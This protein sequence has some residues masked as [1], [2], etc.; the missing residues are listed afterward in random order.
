MSQIVFSL[1][2]IRTNLIHVCNNNNSNDNLDDLINLGDGF[3]YHIFRCGS[4]R[5]QFQNKSFLLIIH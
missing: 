4:K 5:C 3:L 1:V 2:G